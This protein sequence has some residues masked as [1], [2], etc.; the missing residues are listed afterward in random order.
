MLMQIEAYIS[1]KGKIPILLVLMLLNQ[2]C[3][4]L[5][6]A[7]L[8]IVM[9]FYKKNWF[10][11]LQLHDDW[12]WFFT[13]YSSLVHYSL[14]EHKCEFVIYPPIWLNLRRCIL[15]QKFRSNIMDQS[16]MLITHSHIICGV[17]LNLGCNASTS[18][19]QN[20]KIWVLKKK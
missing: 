19:T 12:K 4:T 18:E 13:K 20:F 11:Q 2:E 7:K 15:H 14:L 8:Y 5:G 9:F 1:H 3:L 17:I 16:T 10:Q 6:V